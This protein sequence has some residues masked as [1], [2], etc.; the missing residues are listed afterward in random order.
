MIPDHLEPAVATWCELFRAARERACVRDVPKVFHA[1]MQLPEHFPQAVPEL[2][3]RLAVLFDLDPS[4][5][6]M[7]DI[8][9][10]RAHDGSGGAQCS[11]N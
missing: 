11:S 1:L 8:A 2:E 6:A 9:C 5:R 3:R 10:S 7:F 4:A